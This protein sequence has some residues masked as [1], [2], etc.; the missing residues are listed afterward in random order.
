M[1]VFSFRDRVVEDYGQ[2]SRS[3][4]Q[5]KA[6]DLRDF[7]DGRYGAG[8]YW[9]SPLIQLNPSFVGG[10]SISEL[11]A[12]GLLH[13]ECSRIFRWGKDR[14][15]GVEL[16]LHRHQREAIVIARAGGSLVVISGTGSGKSL[17]YMIPIINRVL[18]ERERGDQGKRIRAIVIYPMNALCNSQIEELQK[19]LGWG[20]PDGPRVTFARYTG[21]ESAEEREKIKNDPPDILLTNYVMLEYILTR[22]DPLDQQVISDA[23]GLEFL[24]LDELH[25]YRGR[26][27]ADVALLVRRVR[28]RLNADL[29]CIGT[30]ATMASEGT[31]AERNGTV[32]QVASKLFGTAIP[33]ETI[34][35]ETLERLTVGD[36]PTAAELSAALD[37]DYSPAATA[38]WTADD[39]RQHPLARWVELRLGLEREDGRADGKWVRCRP[40][41]LQDAALELAK[42]SGRL[43][44]LPSLRQFLLAAYQVEVG[45]NRRF[46]A[47]RL[48][49]FVSAGGDVHASLEAPERRY[50]TLKGQKYQPNAGRQALLYPVVFCRSCGQEFHPV[51]AQLRNRR[52]ERF[53]PRE[54]SDEVSLRDKDVVNGYLMPDADGAY[55]VEDLEQARFPDGWLESDNSGELVL[56][57]TYREFAPVPCRVRADGG[58]G[59][60]G[61]PAW[62]L[63]GSFRFCPSCGVEHNV[64]GSEFRKLCGLNSEGR[65]SATTTLSLA[66]LRQ[67][68]SFPADEIP[69]NARKLL[70]FSDNRQDASLQAGH[71][72][73]FV[74]VLQLRAGLV[75]ALRA[76]P[77]QELSLETLALDTE[78]ALR[79]RADDFIAT[80]GV[81]PNVEAERR[82]ALRGVLE[83]RLL[84]D[85]RK[86]WRLTNPNLEQ[87]RLLEIDYAELVNCAE[88]QADWQQRHPL[89][90]Q[91]SSEERFLILHR[92][93]EELRERLAIDCD[94]LGL[95]E[96][97]RRRKACFDLEEVWAIRA[98]EQPELA[99]TVLMSPVTAE[100]RLQRLEGLSLRSV[101]GRWLKA[102][103]RWL[104]VEELHRGLKWKDDLYQEITGHLL[105]MLTAWGLVKP[106]EVRVGKRKSEVLQ[107]WRLNSSAL[108]WTLVDPETAP[109][110]S[111]A[112]RLREQQESSGRRGPVNSYFRSLYEDL[113]S[114]I[115][116]PS[117]AEGRPFVQTLEAREHTAQVDAGV[118]EQ[119]EKQF[120][121]ARLRLLY[122]SPTMELGVDISS[123]NTVYMRNVPPTPANYAQRSGRAGRSG[124]P[125]LVLSYCGATSPHDQYFFSEPTR[126]VA[127]AVSAPTL[128]LANEEL[129]KA[130]VRALWLAA[131]RQR[132]PSK[133]KELVDLA[134][135]GRPLL[136]DLRDS[137]ASDDACRSAQ[138]DGQA[139]VDDL[140]ENHWLGS[141]PP[142]WLT[143]S[144]LER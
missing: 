20:Y 134:A 79:L 59:S 87:L 50:L 116:D 52:P 142:P 84:V 120:R 112:E 17:G 100:Q 141:T 89:L 33:V 68:L 23:Q 1:D 40:R 91:A 80:K 26:Q 28:Q 4:T 71:F 44:V 56:K 45:P 143:G 88:D 131:T 47:F 123:L 39:L 67:L 95:E 13:P 38:A 97:E 144:W 140:L 103:E 124:Q 60:D 34:V 53:E 133:V 48:H 6:P 10:G 62:F 29:I 115:A 36:L 126:M 107:G 75:A 41:T 61:T 108:R 130:H 7:V 98:E 24:V 119:R 15:D 93:L 54:F 14:G 69:D 11:V 106:K 43:A 42:A 81:K 113:A 110:D 105:A 25:T 121:E 27:G 46:F 19:Y 74:R 73:D 117:Q 129:L 132:L 86:G 58:T 82:R 92:L 16:R 18:E 135:E 96:F 101:F 49:Q 76:R 109:Q 55:A 125:A 51:W 85:L 57:R 94:A 122:C 63:K 104:S 83:Y 111:Y 3:F 118:R 64:R 139:I 114:L 138:A 136:A 2:F 90:A 32:A 22:Q 127:G 66:V 77:E 102:R 8:E 5:I 65:S 128:E 137:L 30:S 35:T 12:E 31:A 21:Q 37:A 72:N 70:A 78:K 9:P 99:R